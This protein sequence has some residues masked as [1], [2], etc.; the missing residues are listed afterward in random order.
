MQTAR[1]VETEWQRAADVVSSNDFAKPQRC[2]GG[3]HYLLQFGSVQC[4]KRLRP[5]AAERHGSFELFG[6]A[7]R[8]T[9]ARGGLPGRCLLGL[10]SLSKLRQEAGSAAPDFALS[11]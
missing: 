6:V 10:H 5:G 3:A 7:S 8:H 2:R 4:P 1:A 11:C 9:V